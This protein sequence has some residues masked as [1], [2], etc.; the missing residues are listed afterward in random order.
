MEKVL[1]QIM[2]SLNVN[3]DSISLGEEE[4]MMNK[5]KTLFQGGGGG[6]PG[7]APVG[8]T[9]NESK[10]ANAVVDKS[11]GTD[12]AAEIARAVQAQGKFGER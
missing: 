3:P 7:G 11:T 10:A 2:K 1:D 8:A 4:I 12:S 9:N 5:L 6:A